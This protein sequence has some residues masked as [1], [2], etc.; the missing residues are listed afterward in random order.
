MSENTITFP[1][2]SE[3]T[4]TTYTIHPFG[5]EWLW[6]AEDGTKP[7]TFSLQKAAAAAKACGPPTS[8]AGSK[9]TTR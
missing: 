5:D 9:A 1:S 2:V 3:D 7:L 6:D 4:L 8:V